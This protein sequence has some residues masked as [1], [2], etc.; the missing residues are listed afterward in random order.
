M[1]SKV[2]SANGRAAFGSIV[3][4]SSIDGLVDT[5][6]SDIHA[7]DAPAL[8]SEVPQTPPIG[9]RIE[10]VSCA[11]TGT[12]IEHCVLWAEQR[13]HPTVEF[14][15]AIASREAACIDFRIECR[16]DSV[17]H[18]A[19]SKPRQRALTRIT[20]GLLGGRCA[21]PRPTLPSPAPT[22]GS[23]ERGSGA[24]CQLNDRTDRLDQGCRR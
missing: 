1:T 12:E 7:N 9:R 21:S 6:E 15:R 8:A 17:R 2:S 14:Y 20:R 3:T 4:A 13:L 19:L 10:V 16:D 24:T 23:H 5:T 11:T 18:L 22:I